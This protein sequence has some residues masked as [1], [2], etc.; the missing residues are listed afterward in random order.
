MAKLLKYDI[1]H[2]KWDNFA[3]ALHNEQVG[4]LKQQVEPERKQEL[5][6]L[7]VNQVKMFWFVFFRNPGFDV[8]VRSLHTLLAVWI[9]LLHQTDELGDKVEGL[10]AVDDCEVRGKQVDQDRQ[11]FE[12]VLGHEPVWLNLWNPFVSDRL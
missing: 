2:P 9:W 7:V 1:T 4:Q 11:K 6:E 5:L 3:L 10:V 8:V 12:F